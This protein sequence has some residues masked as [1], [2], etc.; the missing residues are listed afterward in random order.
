MLRGHKTGVSCVKWVPHR[1]STVVS[2]S[3]DGAVFIWDGRMGQALNVIERHTKDVIS[4]SVSPCGKYVASG[5]TDMMVDISSVDTGERIAT[6]TGRSPIFEVQW[7][8]IGRF[9]S[10]CFDDSTVAIVQS[11]LY[12]Q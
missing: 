4:L 10:I 2:S 3:Q 1:E 5:S 8:P 12:L 7:D 9:L 6:L 11:A